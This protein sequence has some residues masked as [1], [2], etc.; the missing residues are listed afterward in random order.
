MTLKYTIHKTVKLSWTKICKKY[1][2]RNNS[3][4]KNFP[5]GT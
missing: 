4:G 1:L 3:K 5:D 2:A